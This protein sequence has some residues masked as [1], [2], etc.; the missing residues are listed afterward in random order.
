M[1]TLALF[2][3]MFLILT[4]AVP[5]GS[6]S[7]QDSTDSGLFQFLVRV[8]GSEIR[9]WAKPIKNVDMD[10]MLELFESGIITFHTAYWYVEKDDP[11]E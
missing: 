3:L 2:L 5:E 11:G 1:R 7:D 9:P 10:R 8:V 4:G 6:K